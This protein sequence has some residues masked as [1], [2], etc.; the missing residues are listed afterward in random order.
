M[1]NDDAILL[2]LLPMNAFELTLMLLINC[3]ALGNIHDPLQKASGLGNLT[4]T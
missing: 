4:T 2:T 1:T 3:H